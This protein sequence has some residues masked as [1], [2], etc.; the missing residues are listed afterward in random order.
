MKRI[1]TISGNFLLILVAACCTI[2]TLVSAF[3]LDSNNNAIFLAIALTAFALSMGIG[4]FRNKG[5]YISLIPALAAFIWKLPEIALGARHTI[6]LITKEYN[7]WLYVSILFPGA[8]ATKG[9]LTLFLAA[10]GILLVFLLSQTICFYRSAYMTVLFT[11]PIALLTIVLTETLPDF[12]YIIC[13]SIVYLSLTIS[14]SMHPDNY[15]KRGNGIFIAIA[16][17][18]ILSGTAY[19][20]T[21]PGNYRRSI[22]I[23]DIDSYIRNIAVRMGFAVNRMG[24]GWPFRFNGLWRFDTEHVEIANAGPRVITDQSLL[25]ISSTQAG[26]F[27]LRGFSVRTFDGRQWH[28]NSDRQAH[29]DESLS[30][31]MP[32][33][34]V[35][36]YTRAYP[37]NGDSRISMTIRYTGDITEVGYYPYYSIPELAT[38]SVAASQNFHYGNNVSFEAQAMSA[39]SSQMGDNAYIIDFFSPQN[40]ILSLYDKL[41]GEEQLPKYNLREYEDMASLSAYTQ[42]ADSTADGLRKIALEAGIDPGAD[43]EV[44]AKMVADYISGAAR[45]T[46]SPYVIPEDEDFALYFLEN[47]KLGYCIHFATAATLMLRSLNIPARFTSGYIV[48]VSPR[49]VGDVVTVTDRNAHAWVEVYYQNVGWVPLEVTPAGSGSAVPNNLPSVALPVGT[50][51]SDEYEPFDN[52]VAPET[53]N[54]EELQRAAPIEE[55]SAETDVLEYQ[56]NK[57]P[58]KKNIRWVLLIA[59]FCLAV[60]QIRRIT[61]LYRYKRFYNLDTNAAVVYIWRYISG[62]SRVKPPSDLEELALKA[63]FSQHRITEAERNRMVDNSAIF[64]LE[65][66]NSRNKPMQFWLKYFRGV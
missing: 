3:S 64:A 65:L 37:G 47:S 61:K 23:R 10:L 14:S 9:Q 26:V 34:I 19:L 60:S 54:A 52:I 30:I 45:Y 58:A 41:T 28:T 62:L 7:K 24:I 33:I 1:A 31:A 56:D 57:E 16:L 66:F 43:R 8:E 44:I 12:R 55:E 6:F 50:P 11:C 63:R 40:S 5:L 13:L 39:N 29:R 48:S 32:A 51:P 25:E 20:I 21:Q 18:L 53:H 15:I 36:A 17:S 46:L 59:L 4:F 27:Y 2:G 35:D 22:T 38:P 49:E 42:I